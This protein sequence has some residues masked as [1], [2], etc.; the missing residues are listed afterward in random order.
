M[1]AFL[2]AMI[3]LTLSPGPDILY[4]LPLSMSRGGK[5]GAATGCGMATGA[6]GHAFLLAFGFSTL[7]AGSEKIFCCVKIVGSL[8]LFWLAYNVWKHRRE[9]TLISQNKD[10][11]FADRSLV[12]YFLKGFGMAILNPKLILFFLA[13]FPQFLPPAGSAAEMIHLTLFYGLIFA[14]QAAIIFSIVSFCAGTLYRFFA[15]HPKA[16]LLL[17][18]LTIVVLLFISLIFLFTDNSFAENIVA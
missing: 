8:Y 3:L 14:I 7:I 17:N 15:K 4:L 2:I 16:E 10:L 6:L 18:Y 11:A 1:I 13:I 12:S 9:Q 5:V